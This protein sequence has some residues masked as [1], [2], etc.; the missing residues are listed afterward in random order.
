MAITG[1]LFLA[2]LNMSVSTL[3]IVCFSFVFGGPGGSTG[4]RLADRNNS[5]CLLTVPSYG[6]KS[7]RLKR[8]RKCQCEHTQTVLSFRRQKIFSICPFGTK[9]AYVKNDVLK[10]KK[11]ISLISCFPLVFL[12]LYLLN[13]K[14]YHKHTPKHPPKIPPFLKINCH[15]SIG[16]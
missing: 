12:D 13:S 6:Q 9:K 5:L 4:V 7:Q 3:Y 11:I 8:Q 15:F 14:K 2:F 1:K 16:L 10:W